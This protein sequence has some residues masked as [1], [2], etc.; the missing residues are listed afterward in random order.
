[1]PSLH[2]RDDVTIST[3]SS[4]IAP[5]TIPA[6]YFAM[7]CEYLDTV[8]VRS[9]EVLRAAGLER[10]QINQPG[11]IIS[12][13]Q[14]ESLLVAVDE[15]SGRDDLALELGSRINLN[16]H[17]ILSCALLSSVTLDQLL[18]LYSHFHRLICPLFTMQYR[19]SNG[20]A[21]LTFK[22]CMP[23]SR[24]A[25]H[26]WLEVIAVS[27]PLQLKSVTQSRLGTC[28][29]DVPMNKPVDKPGGT[30]RFQN[31]GQLHYHFDSSS[32]PHLRMQFNDLQLDGRLPMG[33]AFAVK[34]AE[35]RCKAMLADFS[36]KSSW[37][38]W[39]SMKLQHAED[40]QP[41]LSELA[42]TL[43]VSTRTLDRYLTRESTSFRDLAVRVRTESAR[44]LLCNGRLSVSQIA[45]ALGYSDIANFSRSFKKVCGLSPTAYRDEFQGRREQRA[46]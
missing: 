10:R 46:A 6:R 25:L 5:P 21:E 16:S 31:V 30:P 23:M 35:E 32:V 4:A 11:F 39:V 7:L 28:R 36:K 20:S 26:F 34:Q 9:D 27:M 22:P 18:S 42:K 33:N 44:E 1:M 19:R 8:S 38:E 12:T 29:V 17:D 45:Y 2:A 24:R 15:I 3:A 40:C 14:M 41:T 13:Q 37:G 43:N